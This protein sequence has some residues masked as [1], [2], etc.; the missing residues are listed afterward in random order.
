VTL[1]DARACCFS[2]LVVYASSEYKTIKPAIE[3]VSENLFWGSKLK[4]KKC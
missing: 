3:L 4:D 1:E 2:F